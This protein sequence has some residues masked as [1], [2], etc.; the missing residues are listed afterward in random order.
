L[1]QF[2]HTTRDDNQVDVFG[3]KKGSRRWLN[4]LTSKWLYLI[5]IICFHSVSLSA[6]LFIWRTVSAE[7]LIGAWATSIGIFHGEIFKSTVSVLLAASKWNLLCLATS[8]VCHYLHYIFHNSSALEWAR[9]RQW[10]WCLLKTDERNIMIPTHN[11][12]H[13]SIQFVFYYLERRNKM[14]ETK[15]S[16]AIRHRLMNLT[17]WVWFNSRACRFSRPNTLGRR[18]KKKNQ[19]IINACVKFFR[20]ITLDLRN[21]FRHWV[22]SCKN[23][24]QTKRQLFFMPISL[25]PHAECRL[26]VYNLSSFDWI[27]FISLHNDIKLVIIFYHDLLEL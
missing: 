3:G 11:F 24:H 13:N 23:P 9:Q 26:V 19:N 20:F 14:K 27:V 6:H 5:K 7:P 2:I 17:F 8:G 21:L 18:T 1:R 4:I 10:Y 16:F 12:H 15:T 25:S 22:K